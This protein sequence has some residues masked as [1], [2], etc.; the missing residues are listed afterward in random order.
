[1]MNPLVATFVY[2]VGIALLFWLDRDADLKTSKALWIPVAWFFLSCSRPATLWLAVFGMSP[3]GPV[4]TTEAQYVDGSPIDRLIYVFLIL[5]GLAILI[6]GKR[7]AGQLLSKN[8]AIVLF[9]SF[10]LLSVTWSDYSLVALKH[11]IKGIGDVVMVVLVL[12]DPHPKVALKRFLTRVGFVV[13]PL[14]VLYAKY[15]PAVGREYNHWT[16]T[17]MYSG[18][19]ETKN[20]LGMIC[21]IFGLAS[22]WQLF[23]PRRHETNRQRRRHLAAY[24]ILLTAVLWL[25]W[26]SDSMTSLSCLIL[27]TVLF[28]AVKINKTARAGAIH[29]L[30]ACLLALPLITL[31]F[32]AGSGMVG[33]LGRDPTLTGRTQI[34]HIVLKFA[35]SP[36]VGTGYESFWLGSRLQAVW[37]D[38][39]PGIQEAHNGYLEIYLNLGWIGAILLSLV[40]ITGYGHMMRAFRQDSSRDP[41]K[42][43]V[44][45]VGLV[46]NLTEAGFRMAD[47]VW[48]MFLLATLAVTSEVV[49]HEIPSLDTVVVGGRLA[50][51]GQAIPAMNTLRAEGVTTTAHGSKR[52]EHSAVKSELRNRYVF[53]R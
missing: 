20:G 15:Y 29:F 23:E 45:L 35:G 53:H 1:M 22:V 34:W 13:I 46:Y 14:S 28:T 25:L 52:E 4:G 31:F 39:T 6:A 44:F 19:T 11:W 10:C 47:P 2:L 27:G 24:V 51:S 49:R 37:R 38:F 36:W 21:L 16:W 5:A 30:I 48:I 7:H 12:T 9:F 43:A 26:K 18:V 42:L 17:P 50:A 40:I 41:F 33:S 8:W 3:S 32:D